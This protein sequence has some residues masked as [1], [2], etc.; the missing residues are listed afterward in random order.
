SKWASFIISKGKKN[1]TKR[2]LYV[3]MFNY[4]LLF[5]IWVIAPIVFILFL[6][7]YLPLY[8][9]LKKEKEYYSSVALK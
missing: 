9:K 3:K 2:Q 8:G 7:T 1:E 4:Y 6:L 5:A